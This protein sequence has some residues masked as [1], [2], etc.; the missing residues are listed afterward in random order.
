MNSLKTK[1]NKLHYLINSK[2]SKK[3]NSVPVVNLLQHLS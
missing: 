1:N 3:L 2:P